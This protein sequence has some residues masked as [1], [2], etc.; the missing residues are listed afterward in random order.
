MPATA[1]H[2]D[3]RGS[4][5]LKLANNLI[6]VQIVPNI[7]GRIIQLKLEDFEYFWVNDQLGGK[8]PT[9]SGVGDNDTWLNYGGS[10][11]WPAPQG[12]GDDNLWPG[13][14]DALLDGSPHVGSV[15][16]PNGQF[17]S[18]Q[19]TSQKDKRSGIQFTRRIKLYESSAQVSIDC[20][21][22]NIDT[23]PRRWGI[24]Q[25]TQHNTANRKHRGYDENVHVY[26]PINTD[27]KHPKGYKVI[28]GSD[29][30][31]E[32]NIE[33]GMMSAKYLHQVGKIGIDCSAGWY[34]LVNETYGYVFVERFD[35]AAGRE[36]PDDSSFELWTQ[37]KG[38]I[39]AYGKEIKMPDK[40]EENPYLLE[41]EVLSPFARIGPGESSSFHTDWYVT[42][43][44]EHLPVIACN[45]VGVTCKPLQ[46]SRSG[47]K[48]TVQNGHFGV[49]EQGEAALAFV[50]ADEGEIDHGTARISV[51]PKRPLTTE[52]LSKLVESVEIPS[53]TRQVSLIILSK[54]RGTIGQLA[55]TDI[56]R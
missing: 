55:S 14:P 5:S 16:A 51:S 45:T 34:A 25:V 11:L 19:V 21:M 13:P 41:T 33:N 3:Y 24:W 52:E 53:K 40:L 42:K 7:G 15:I 39:Q 17:A 2:S 54:S 20:R 44:G 23:K 29:D 18:V 12:W 22:E 36:Y 27:S 32:F 49:F 4:E 28:Y 26:C 30:N 6:E 43:I 8:S 47:D 9:A 1:T 10:K 35:W 48:L 37:G 46:V 31:P 38:T 56:S 50:D